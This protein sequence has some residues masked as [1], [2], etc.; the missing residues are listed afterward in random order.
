MGKSENRS[1]VLPRQVCV[2][3]TLLIPADYSA[4]PLETVAKCFHLSAS[5]VF[6][7]LIRE[8][9]QISHSP[10][11]KLSLKETENIR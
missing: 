1:P 3:Q 8:N 10:M 6:T 11:T 2:L 4:I 5:L 7:K 9:V